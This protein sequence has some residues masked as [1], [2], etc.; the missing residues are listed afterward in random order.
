MPDL[1]T[2]LDVGYGVVCPRY[3]TL[4]RRLLSAQLKP[5]LLCFL[6]ESLEGEDPEAFDAL[7][8]QLANG[9]VWPS[10]A[11]LNDLVLKVEQE[12]PFQ[13]ALLEVYR[14]GSLDLVAVRNGTLAWFASE[15]LEETFN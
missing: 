10:G 8:V 12:E 9:D 5:L 3:P 1:P 11:A 4:E 15:S 6:F 14:N 2:T 13:F 7:L